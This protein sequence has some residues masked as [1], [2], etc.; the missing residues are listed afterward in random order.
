M[1]VKTDAE[2]IVVP[3]N[4]VTIQDRAFK[5]WKELKQIIFEPGSKLKCIGDR[6]FEGTGLVQFI[7]P[8]SLKIIG[9]IAF[10]NCKSLKQVE[11]NDTL[12]ELGYY[13]FWGTKVPE[14]DIPNP[15]RISMTWE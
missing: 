6:A 11:L 15:D 5:G 3:K 14:A 7:A 9:D 2:R 8:P 4:V 1:F 13:C 10:K 12:S